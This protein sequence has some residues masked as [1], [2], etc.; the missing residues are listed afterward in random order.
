MRTPQTKIIHKELSYK[1]TGIAFKT[2]D[3]L[4]RYA[5]EKQYADLFEKLLQEAGI[6]Y[7]REKKISK[8]G[9]DIN[10]VDFIIENVLVVELKAKPFIEKHPKEFVQ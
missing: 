3:L 5:L 9:D 10:R 6:K 4:G 1:V 8:T 7:G 2:K